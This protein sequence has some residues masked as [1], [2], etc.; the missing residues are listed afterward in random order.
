MGSRII[1]LHKLITYGIASVWL[2]NGVVCK[3][4]HGV[5]RHQ[6]IVARIL[7][8]SYAPQLTQLIGA[9]E[10][11]LALWII[12]FKWSRLC[13]C[14]QIGLVALMNTI[15]W[16]MAPDLLLFGRFN[17]INALLFIGLIYGNEFWL[18]SSRS[19]RSL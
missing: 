1:K 11:V 4:L 17:A 6:R 2:I 7:G 5:P 16:V 8:E 13:A 10:L 9:A 12:S 18:T 19:A 15:E 3:L 14:T